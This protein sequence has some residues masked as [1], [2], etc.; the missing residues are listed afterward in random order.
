MEGPLTDME[1]ILWTYQFSPMA[2]NSRIEK[3]DR[4]AN[5]CAEGAY[6]PTGGHHGD[7][8]ASLLW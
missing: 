2:A 1:A 6:L 8:P 3:G 5:R 4:A 7:L